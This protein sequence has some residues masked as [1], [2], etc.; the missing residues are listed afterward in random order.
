MQGK[1][2]VYRDGK[3]IITK[4]RV[5]QQCMV[6]ETL[7]MTIWTC[8]GSLR[9]DIRHFEDIFKKTDISMYIESRQCINSKLPNV[10]GYRWES[11]YNQY[12]QV[13]GNPKVTQLGSHYS[14]YGHTQQ[15]PD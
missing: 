8:H 2:V 15:L 11:V 4:K 3:V 13:A 12:L 5:A 9:T 14:N 10:Q 6:F 7:C 1:R